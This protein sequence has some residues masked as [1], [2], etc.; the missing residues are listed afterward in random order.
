MVFAIKR[1]PPPPTPLMAQISRH[2]FTPLFSLQ[3]NLTYMKH[4]LHLVSVK[5]ITFKSSYDLFKIDILRLP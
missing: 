1:R 5:I 3:L 4:M 2:F